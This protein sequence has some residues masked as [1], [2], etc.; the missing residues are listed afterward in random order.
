MRPRGLY[1]PLR[2]TAHAITWR[3]VAAGAAM[4]MIV[5]L[6]PE[7]LTERHLTTLARLAAICVQHTS[8]ASNSR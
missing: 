7:A 5:L 2:P 4:G 6:V 3:P 8:S 1:P